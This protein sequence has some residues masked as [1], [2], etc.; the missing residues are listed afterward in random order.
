[1]IRRC[2]FCGEKIAPD[3]TQCEHCGKVLKVTEG[4][5]AEGTGLT[6]LDTWQDKSVPS[7]VMYSV[8]GFAVI[9]AAVM[10]VDG[11]NGISGDKNPLAPAQTGQT[12]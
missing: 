10:V 1:M 12:E 11:C 5:V 9:V 2:R 4:P 7:W 3:A 8:I 6:N